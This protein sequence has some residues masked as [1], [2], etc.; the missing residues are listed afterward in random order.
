MRMRMEDLQAWNTSTPITT[1]NKFECLSSSKVA[2]DFVQVDGSLYRV[3]D[4]TI[5]D[6]SVPYAY[7]QKTT[8]NDI[9]VIGDSQV[10]GLS[11]ALIK[12][13]PKSCVLS[14][15]GLKLES[16]TNKPLSRHGNA[17]ALIVGTSNIMR[18]DID[19]TCAKFERMIDT[20]REDKNYIIPSVP[21]HR[22]SNI[23]HKIK[24]VNRFIATSCKSRPHVQYHHMY[25]NPS[26]LKHDG[27]HLN[28]QGL[29]YLAKELTKATEDFWSEKIP[30]H[31]R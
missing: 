12:H 20:L 22:N 28:K 11:E 3:V 18:E 27:M 5:M 8:Q 29:N 2:E 31:Q 23:N 7:L 19:T 9:E 14:T 17:T 24:A 25:W 10:R 21:P 4:S 30:K 26:D 6:Q 13:I 1:H 15:S 16:L